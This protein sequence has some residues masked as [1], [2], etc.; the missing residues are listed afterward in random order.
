M[1][2]P[3]IFPPHVDLAQ[4]QG[5]PPALLGQPLYP[6]SVAGHPLLPPRANTQMQLAVMQQLQQQRPSE[7]KFRQILQLSTSTLVA[8]LHPL[9]GYN[10]RQMGLIVHGKFISVRFCI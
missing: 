5:M 7:W 3:G 8:A 1:Y 2:T 10:S 6:L 4:L 9:K